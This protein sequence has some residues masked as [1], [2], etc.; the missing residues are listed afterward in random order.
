ML[1]SVLRL[2]IN[3]SL[4]TGIFPDKLKMAVVTPIYKGKDSD[5]H[6][7]GNYRPISLLPTLSKIFEKVV[8]LQLY[9]YI[10]S[11]NLLNKSQYGFRPNHATEYAAMEFVDQTMQ[12]LDKGNIPLSIFLDL[13]KAFDTL[14]HKILLKKLHFYGIRGIYLEWFSSYLSNR[15]QY[16]AY[17]HKL[18]H[19]L[20][21]TT[22]VPQ[23]SVLGPLLFLIYINDISEAS[24]QFHAIMFADD[25]SLLST[26][27][28]FYTF[29]PKT[30][31]DI[32]LLCETINYEISLVTDWLKIN[33]LSIN[34]DKTKYM[35]IHNCQKQMS[36]YNQIQLKLDGEIIKRTKSFN[37]L[38]IVINEQLNWNNHITHL[39]S[40]INPTVGMLHRLKNQLPTHIMKMIYNSLILSQLHYGNILWGGR[41][42]SLIKLNKKA[43]RA[44]ANV[45][46]NTHT[47]PIEKK[48]KLLS[49][50]DI[51]KLKK[52]CLY[53]KFIDDKLPKY[54]S[55]MFKNM[56]LVSFPNYPKTVKYRNTIRFEL[57]TFLQTAPDVLMRKSQIVSYWCFKSNVKEYIIERYSSLCTITGCISCHLRMHIP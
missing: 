14:D 1:H 8:H 25:T 17:N 40:K 38:G 30:K 34:T 57:P 23:G 3:K 6:E 45:G 26:L 43:L 10:N 20:Q 18:S 49:V 21:L 4:M 19:P 54:I 46:Y 55:T 22:G 39:S 2:I 11:N 12:E 47:N 27:R 24:K 51:H 44:I 56:S 35:I 33:K 29:K 31:Q 42:A 50:P 41:P 48:L 36:L 53:K 7:F 37:F 9:D 16:V 28:T 5:P 15:T 52:Y 13:S 32:D